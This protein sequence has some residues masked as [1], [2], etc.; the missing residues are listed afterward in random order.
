MKNLC[1]FFAVGLIF[2]SYNSKLFAPIIPGQPQIAIAETDDFLNRSVDRVPGVPP[3]R[4]GTPVGGHR[5]EFYRQQAE[6]KRLTEEKLKLA[7][8]LAEQNTPPKAKK[9]IAAAQKFAAKQKPVAVVP[10]KAQQRFNDAQKFAANQQ[11]LPPA[12]IPKA[13]QKIKAAQQFADQ[14]DEIEQAEVRAREYRQKQD[15]AERNRILDLQ[16]K[17]FLREEL[18][19]RD[20]A[21]LI[22]FDINDQRVST[23]P[24]PI[25]SPSVPRPPSR[26][27]QI[28]DKDRDREVADV[29][30]QLRREVGALD[31]AF[32]VA[33]RGDNQSSDQQNYVQP[34]QISSPAPQK[35]RRAKR[36]SEPTP[37][38]KPILSDELS[39]INL[40]IRKFTQEWIASGRDIDDP[41]FNGEAD[42]ITAEIS[43]KYRANDSQ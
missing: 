21:D 3:P 36:V 43:A 27:S 8:K 24:T 7:K 14:I 42:R 6:K 26:R 31:K 28:I 39:E 15:E 2:V 29:A 23:Q 30:E 33:N 16:R 37:V 25:S 12:A 17:L 10:T 1:K 5:A 22:V 34:A 38:K 13:Q 18:T 11:K 40:A 35:L 32:A 4:P 20:R 19:E 9:N 41:A